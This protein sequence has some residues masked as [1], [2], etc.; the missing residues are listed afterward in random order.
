VL[1]VRAAVSV[2]GKGNVSE[3]GEDVGKSS[4]ITEMFEG[5]R[6]RADKGRNARAKNW[7]TRFRDRRCSSSGPFPSTS[8]SGLT[9]DFHKIRS[10][11]RNKL[12][13]IVKLLDVL[14]SLPAWDTLFMR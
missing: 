5:W 3:T 14:Q 9:V 2:D 10:H 8:G 12:V 1:G 13:K 7:P 11:L 6:A 4:N